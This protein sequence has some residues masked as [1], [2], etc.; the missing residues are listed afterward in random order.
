MLTLAIDTATN[1][2]SC[3]L[4]EDGEILIEL[5]MQY[6]KTHSQKIVSMIKNMLNMVD[7]DVADIDLYAVSVGPGS[8]TGLRIGV[9]T[10]KGLAYAHKKPVCSIK[11]LD[12]LA[13]S[14][15]DFKGLITPMLDA[16]NNQVFTALY[17]KDNNSLNKILPETGVHIDEWTKTLDSF[18]ENILILGDAVPLHLEDLKAKLKKR[19]VSSNHSISYPRAAAVALLA[20]QAYNNNQYEGA[21]ET[22]PMYL[23]KSQAERMKELKNSNN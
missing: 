21:F 10:I 5:N 16:R 18:N 23:R 2:A 20:E 4:A 6:G 15:P 12:A 1:C 3:A 7:K 22:K 8:F 19:V 9:V 17:R 13:F 14:M 11:T